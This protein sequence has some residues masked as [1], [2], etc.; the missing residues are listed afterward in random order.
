VNQVGSMIT[1]F[2]TEAPVVTDYATAKT[3]DTEKFGRWFR[4]LLEAGVYWPPSQFEAAFLSAAMTDEDF[5]E[6]GSAA[7]AALRGL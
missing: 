6:L 5:A 1:A 4:S 7:G 2:F 3:C